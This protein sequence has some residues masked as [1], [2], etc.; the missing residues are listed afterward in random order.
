M[1][2]LSRLL[3]LLSLSLVA[4]SPLTL[5]A[6]DIEPHT[7]PVSF[8]FK[9]DQGSALMEIKDGVSG[10]VGYTYGTDTESPSG[11]AHMKPG[12]DYEMTIA[13]SGTTDYRLSLIAPSGY[14]FY[15]RRIKQNGTAVTPLTSLVPQ[16][17]IVE[18]STG[19]GGNTD[20]YEV[21][22]RP[23]REASLAPGVFTGINI[24]QAVTWEL[25][26]G[27]FRAGSSAGRVSFRESDLSTSPASRARLVYVP[28][29]EST[30]VNVIRDGPS[31]ANIRQIVTPR[32]MVDFVDVTDGY[33]VRYYNYD[34]TTWV[35]A[36]PIYT[37]NSGKTPW[38]TIFVEAPSGTTNQLRIT[39]T[40]ETATTTA[41]VSHLTLSSG[42]VSSG[43]YKW[44]L[45]E[46]G[47]NNNWLRTTTHDSTTESNTIAA[48][49]G[50]TV[51]DYTRHTFTSSG[52]FT[53]TSVPAGQTL[54]ALIVAGGGG[55][56]G[57]S[58]NGGGGGGGGGVL[59]TTLTPTVTSYTI[60]VGAGGAG[61]TAG[62]GG[63]GGNSTAFTVTANGGGGGGTYQGSGATGGSGGGGGRDAGTQTGG[64]SGTA[65]QG[66]SG[67]GAGGG[68]WGSAGGGGG[69]GAAGEHGGTDNVNWTSPYGNGGVGVSNDITGTTQWY[70][71][72]G[73]GPWQTGSS[74]P[75]GGNG[76]GG[77]AQGS[78]NVGGSGTN[79]TGGG[80]AGAQY[81][82][83]GAG[84]SGIVVIRYYTG[85]THRNNLVTVRTGGTTGD[86]VSETKYVYKTG[87]AWGEDL[88]Q[89]IVNPNGA[90]G[91]ELTTTYAYY[92]TAPSTGS[93]THRGNYRRVKSITGPTG[94]WTAYEYHDEWL[95]RG[96]TE[97]QFKPY[98]NLPAT[99]TLDTQKGRVMH[100]TYI[101][102]TT[103]RHRRLSST[104]E[105]IKDE[106][107]T[108]AQVETTSKTT[109]VYTASSDTPKRIKVEVRNHY[110]AS[111]AD[112]V[113]S[114]SER[115]DPLTMDIDQAG[116]PYVV[117]NADQSQTSWSR[118]SGDYTISTNT[119][120]VP[121]TY[122]YYWRILKIK[123]STVASGEG[124]QQTSYDGQ[125]FE[126]IYLA[127]NKSTM[128][129][130]VLDYSGV[131]LR[132]ET[133][134]YKGSGTWSDPIS[135]VVSDYD[136]ARTNR[137]KSQTVS[138][139]TT[140]TDNVG[141][142]K[143]TYSAD[144]HVEKI[145]V[146]REVSSVFATQ[147]ET[148]YTYDVLGRALTVT[149]I[150]TA[151]SGIHAEQA[152]LTTT[153]VYDGANRVTTVTRSAVG[154]TEEI[155]SSKT[156][157]KA[158]RVKT[159]T[160]PG[161]S[162]TTYDYDST[163]RTHKTTTPDGGVIVKTSNLDGSLASVTDGTPGGVT[164]P[165]PAV[166]ATYY[167]YVVESDGQQSVQVNLGS[168]TSPRFTK[169]WT[170]LLGRTSKSLKPG[171]SQT[172]QA[173]YIEEN[174]YSMSTG[175][176][177]KTTRTGYTAPTRYEYNTLGQMVRSGLDIDNDGDLEL[178]SMDRITDTETTFE[179]DSGTWWSKKTT[180][181]Y[182]DD[183]ANTHPI[184]T[185]S[186][187]RLNQ[188]PT[189]RISETQATDAEGNTVTT[190][191]DVSGKLVTTQTTVPGIT[192][193]DSYSY[194]YNGMASATKDP[195]GLIMKVKYDKLG[196]LS[197][198]TDDRGNTTT[199]TYVDNT[200]MVKTVTDAAT[201]ASV[202]ENKYDDSGRVEWSKDAQGHYTRYAYNLRG[203]VIKQW[204]DAASPVLYTYDTS[205]I[206]YGELTGL[207]TYRSAPAEDSTSW[208]TVGTA[209]T[210]TMSYDPDTGLLW[211]KIDAEGEDVVMDYNVRGQVSKRTL[212]RGVYTEYAY[213]GVT[214]ELTDQTYSDTT[215]DIGYTYTRLGQ[216]KKVVDDATGDWNF[217]Y[218]DNKPWR[219]KSTQLPT[220]YGT[221]YQTPLYETTGMVGAYKGFKLGSAYDSN[222]DLEQ[223]YTYATNGRFDT[224]TTK[225]NGSASGHTF[226]YSYLADTP[227][228]SGYTISEVS[229][230]S[231]SRGYET[232]R[233]LLNQVDSQWNGISLTRYDYEHDKRYLRETSQQS[234]S[235]FS[236]YYVT[237]SYTSVFNH[238]TYN[239]RSELE[240]STMYHG[241]TA[242]ITPNAAAA[243][244][245]RRF[246]Y[247][248]DSIGNRKSS[249]STGVIGSPDDSYTTNSLNQYDSRQ[250]NVVSV[251]GIATKAG[252]NVAVD[253][254]T[255]TEQK[256]RVWAADFTPA[257]SSNP[258]SGTTT[259]YAADPGE[260]TGGLDLVVSEDI[261]Y[262]VPK[263]AEDYDYDEDGN[264]IGD[265]I[266]SYEYDAE[267]RLIIM[268]VKSAVIGTGKVVAGDAQKLVF[269]YDYAGR[270]V[271]KT[272]YNWD[273]GTTAY[274]TT[275]A[276]DTKYL[277]DGWNLIAEFNVDSLEAMTMKRSYTWGLD[278]TGDLTA[279]GGVGGLVQIYDEAGSKTLLPTYDGNGNIAALVNASGGGL[280]AI[281]EY[282]PY[283]NLI[284]KEGTYAA[285]NPFRFSTKYTD[286]ETDL[287]YYGYRYYSSSMGRFINRDPIEE[288]GGL[289]LY[290]FVGNNAIN[291]WDYL[292]MD[293]F[294][295][296]YMTKHG[297]T[298]WI[299][300]DGM[301]G[302]ALMEA[303][304]KAANTLNY[305]AQAE[306][307]MASARSAV[308]QAILAKAI[309]NGDVQIIGSNADGTY[310][311]AVHTSE[312][313]TALSNA[314]A[315]YSAAT[316]NAGII[317]TIDTS[318]MSAAQYA[319]IAKVGN[320]PSSGSS[321]SALIEVPMES[322]D[323][324]TLPPLIVNG[325]MATLEEDMAYAA[326]LYSINN[327]IDINGTYYHMFSPIDAQVV[328]DRRFQDQAAEDSLIIPIRNAAQNGGTLPL[329]MKSGPSNPVLEDDYLVQD[330]TDDISL[331]GYVP[332]GRLE[333][334]PSIGAGS[335]DPRGSSNFI[336]ASGAVSGSL[337]RTISIPYDWDVI[338]SATET[339]RHPHG[340]R[341]I[342]VDIYGPKEVE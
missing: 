265:S 74:Q 135:S 260:G 144:G 249:G 280:E 285:S 158:G 140:A 121:G 177:T 303:N 156:Y 124:T 301:D 320:A 102:D 214:G 224:L 127:P 95:K 37:I 304:I 207:S 244:P 1:P 187:Q 35:P 193:G 120:T 160:S 150:G 44:T 114:Y 151:A 16:D 130:T 32:I 305:I 52:T 284:R 335:P 178:A 146:G 33:E 316:G 34:D 319:A 49:G 342:S 139:G 145:E 337:T 175:Q 210:T 336:P 22:I 215:P 198:S 53:T 125:S 332:D 267:N 46:G 328:L 341:T 201:P 17:F 3:S 128:D 80:G 132:T 6:V 57:G 167:T 143:Y 281:Y 252:A 71:G 170:D 153:S 98:K 288:S 191:T 307:A 291:T 111:A 18:T 268:Y 84:G 176:L 155:V 297:E 272:T 36:T 67:G 45:Q 21:Q 129:V 61:G 64:A 166:V 54:D 85:T 238:Y 324:V 82:N 334:A 231:V 278:L 94:G 241:D 183:N 169:T 68:S 270:R 59:T 221:R 300:G 149:K 239:A 314:S 51:G 182:P 331:R 290:G 273:T 197:E 63:M 11:S 72:G 104:T 26:L 50:A 199:T 253:E 282:D 148:S 196:R 296:T 211:K 258:V 255:T 70:G 340:D 76:G 339:R 294:M 110:S 78:N 237:G 234:G 218:D 117:K 20:T 283:G 212:A 14:Q 173:D 99:P 138:N 5:H 242:S 69:A 322:D 47:P 40:Y 251:L 157:D 206:G 295:T 279:A 43:V 312:G 86:I 142:T 19:G 235:A 232:K 315:S 107:Q 134:I 276:T 266:W 4:L 246:E 97:Y 308:N 25:G 75:V 39:E 42:S 92:E 219:L 250:N 30:Q 271:R 262:L 327:T 313:E 131:P 62:I 165:G 15:A 171:F 200:T 133:R 225:H 87:Y 217:D 333:S 90:S 223:T 184:V 179:L 83:G 91:E 317:G 181:T 29:Y 163:N 185:T 209:D 213:S 100:Y 195:A 123:G 108:G 233:D 60:T 229:L 204:G 118:S 164:I 277:Y 326:Y 194:T 137:L 154:E 103:G 162:A 299:E 10:N 205:A 289:N 338:D 122:G 208:P 274:S 190:V 141:V 101:D 88:Y 240:G 269:V 174:T 292:G 55:G 38:K 323:V 105:T 2:T 180:T 81:A 226:N 7:L 73:A 9:I 257:N 48:T 24:G 93:E 31:T 310:S 275:K 112:Y 27:T 330:L 228:V 28:P 119:F 168:A 248:Y 311:V 115:I 325:S 216:V 189:G 298:V 23:N 245:G 79:G 302:Q 243:L 56:G 8:S 256:D 109:R 188:F 77:D 116:A 41:R 126:G 321:G 192:A 309:E 318:G 236:D 113:D 227:F 286:N 161:L 186:K 58:V 202:V 264:L 89:V 247:R 329:H 147:S 220:F 96:Q 287:V 203:Q 259:V 306:S 66:N 230:F 222:A 106:S 136:F 65:G 159:V 293:A 254:A 172:S 12:K 261:S 152:D 13:W 263:R